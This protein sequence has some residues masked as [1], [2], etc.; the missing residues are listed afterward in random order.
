[1]RTDFAT[2]A[3]EGRQDLIGGQQQ[4]T[5]WRGKQVVQEI[6]DLLVTCVEPADLPHLQLHHIVHARPSTDHAG[7]LLV[8]AAERRVPPGGVLEDRAAKPTPHDQ[9]RR[10][11]AL[12]GRAK[13]SPVNGPVACWPARVPRAHLDG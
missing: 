4:L 1:M 2:I 9:A 12:T 10:K 8:H 6:E 7:E 5:S 13:G 11:L 3:V